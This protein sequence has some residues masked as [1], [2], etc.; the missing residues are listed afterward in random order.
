MKSLLLDEKRTKLLLMAVDMLEG[1]ESTN[2]DEDA[3]L[4]DLEDELEATLCDFQL[5]R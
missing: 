4:R 1:S 5:K 3:L 2:M